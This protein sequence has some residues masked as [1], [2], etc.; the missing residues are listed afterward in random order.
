MQEIKKFID[1]IHPMNAGDWN[2]FASKLHKQTLKKNIPLI[3]VGDVE[4]Y[5]SFISEG[6]VRYYIPQEESDLT[7]GFLFEN[8]FVTAYD[9]FITQT[10]SPYQIETLTNTTLWRITYNDLQ[11]VYHK[12]ESGNII[13]RRMAENMF[14]IKSKREIALLRKTAEERYL[15]L[16]SERPK[17]LKKIPLKYI[18]SYI[19]VTPQALS[20]IRK[21][22]T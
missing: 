18:A 12:T 1:H 19:G 22:I 9:S 3:N 7:F 13:G 20:R 5:L 17:L 21:R 16:F 14:L 4:N 11:E 8:Q 15:D 6:I 2:F 10:P